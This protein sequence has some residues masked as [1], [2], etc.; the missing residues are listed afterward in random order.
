VVDDEVHVRARTQ[1]VRKRGLEPPR[2]L[3]H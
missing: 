3:P 1:R 2:V